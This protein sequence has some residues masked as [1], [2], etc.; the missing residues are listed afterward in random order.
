MT[1][2]LD[3]LDGVPEAER[4]ARYASELV[5]LSPA[6]E[7]FRGSGT[8]EGRIAEAPRGSEGFGY[9][10]VFVP[11]GEELTVAESGTPGRR[12]RSHRAGAAAALLKAVGRAA[13]AR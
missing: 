6:G 11:E 5:C 7:E 10:P 3:E 1:R 13:P 4:G 12:Q 9:D 2:L 8:L